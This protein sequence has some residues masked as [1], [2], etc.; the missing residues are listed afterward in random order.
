V[1]L[2][3]GTE[4][5]EAAGAIIKTGIPL[6]G[7]LG[8]TPQSAEK[9]G[10][11]KVQ[12]KTA[13]GAKV[14]IDDAKKLERA[15]CFSIVLECIPSEIAAII[16]RELSIPTIGIGAGPG[17]DGQVLVINDMAGLFDR[18]VPKFVK[19]YA[20]LS[21]Q[22]TSAVRAYKEEVESGKFPT[23]EH[24]FTIKAEELKKI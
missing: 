17:C 7:H 15:G 16:T 10:G 11:F 13:E 9:L 6:M 22:I 23:S 24:E 2:E 19:Q 21:T 5:L 12:G 18:F 14:I 1:K 3:G 8:L 4:S 20:K